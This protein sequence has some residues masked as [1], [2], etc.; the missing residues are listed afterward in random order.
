MTPS[1][2]VISA[3]CG[4]FWQESTLSPG[5]WQNLTPGL[6]TDLRKGYGLGQWTNVNG[7]TH[8]RL[9]QLTT[10]LTENG[11]EQDDGDGQLAFLL[12]ENLWIPHADYTFQTLTEFLQSDSTD[13]E[14]L[15]HAFNRCWEGIHD[16]SW[17][18]RVEFAN[19]C[20]KYIQ[21]HYDDKSI[22]RWYTENIYLP[23]SN[24][25]NNAVM[26]YR[27]LTDS[28]PPIKPKKSKMPIWM[29]IKYHY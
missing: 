28:T 7:D 1:I 20:Y 10:W 8:G 6:P 9:Y 13:I 12:Y 17:D 15:T 21:D 23:E 3:I 26:I 19:R 24:T 4:N 22:T 11:Y 14:M 5:V 16:Q 2:Y 27:Y 18:L 25:L 29:W